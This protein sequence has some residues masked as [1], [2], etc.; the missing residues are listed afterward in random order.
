MR[1]YPRRFVF[2]NSMFFGCPIR[3][4]NGCRDFDCGLAFFGGSDRAFQLANDSF[5]NRLFGLTTTEGSFGTFGNWHGGSII[6]PKL[7]W[8]T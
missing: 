3:E 8:K 1:F 6:E 7:K 5:I 2:V 4:G